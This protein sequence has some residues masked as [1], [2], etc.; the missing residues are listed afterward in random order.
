MFIL[1][2]KC[3]YIYIRSKKKKKEIKI[4]NSQYLLIA[5]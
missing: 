4:T 2:D 5:L 3:V 1:K